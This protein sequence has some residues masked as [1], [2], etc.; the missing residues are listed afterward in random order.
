[1]S[2]RNVQEEVSILVFNVGSSSLSFKL[3]KHS[4]VLLK[5]KCHR[6]GVRTSHPSS[7]EFHHDEMNSLQDIDLPDHVTAVRYVLDYL[8]GKGIDFEAVGHRFADGGGYFE[9][10]TL[11]DVDTRSLLDSC[12]S[13]APLH[14][15]AALAMIDVVAERYPLVAQFVVFDSTFHTGL[16]D[17][18]RAYAL[19][20][21]LADRY[22]KHGFH[23]LSY[24]DVLEQA[25]WYLGETHF[26]AIA[27]HL[28]TGGSSVCALRDGCSVDTSMGYSPLQ[29]LVMNTRCGDID[30]GI[31][32]ELVQQ[33]YSAEELTRT[34]HRESGL[35]GLSGG[36]SSDIRDLAIV[37]AHDARAK[38]AFD[39]YVYR[40]KQYV[41]AY[42][43]VMNGLDVLV[44]T[45]DVGLRVPEV[46][47]AMCHHMDSLGIELDEM[48]NAAASPDRIEPLHAEG[49]RVRILAIPNDEERA[50]YAE[51]V[52]LL[53]NAGQDSR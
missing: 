6:V 10:G 37:M 16:P 15:V 22:R 3:Y 36:T 26:K 30:P 24:A 41:G 51:G 18:A 48:R 44:F 46:R 35:F 39:L 21:A 33:G 20:V 8:D 43:A 49:S 12:A 29:G 11:V 27:L 23:G 32:I 13:L 40:V 34:L 9:K 7:V 52:E 38:L 17:V 42:V 31:I 19:P 28:G 5:G 2:T 4:Q 14:N 50:I 53:Q 25:T 1:M 45:D 47:S